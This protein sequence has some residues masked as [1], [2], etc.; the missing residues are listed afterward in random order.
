MKRR[1][2]AILLVLMLSFAFVGNVNAEETPITP[3]ATENATPETNAPTGEENEPVAGNTV[4][5]TEFF[6]TVV[7]PLILG[8]GSGGVISI[9]A[10]L[11]LLKMWGRLKDAVSKARELHKSN[12]ASED[13]LSYLKDLLSKIDVNEVKK[14]LDESVAKAKETLKIDEAMLSEMVA[15]L[16]SLKAMQESFMKAAQNA[17][18]ASPAAVELLTGADNTAI[19]SMAAKITAYESYIRTEKGAE[20]ENIIHEIEGV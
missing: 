8:L 14:E 4:T 19:K 6:D 13:E 10:L 2:F 17:W 11:A 20:A 3:P 18:S 7:M 15:L 9:G 12:K 5:T 1:F 16:E